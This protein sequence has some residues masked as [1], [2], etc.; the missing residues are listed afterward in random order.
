MGD[1]LGTPCVV[2]IYFFDFDISEQHGIVQ[3]KISPIQMLLTKLL[4]KITENKR[5][6]ILLHNV[7]YFPQFKSKC[8]K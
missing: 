2:G 7:I 3:F 6:E 1:C 4:L 5:N 8:K